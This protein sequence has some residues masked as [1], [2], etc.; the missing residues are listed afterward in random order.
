MAPRKWC[1][2][3]LLRGKAE[4]DSGMRDASGKPIRGVRVELYV[5]VDRLEPFLAPILFSDQ[6][7]ARMFGLLGLAGCFDRFHVRF[8]NFEVD[9]K[10]PAFSLQPREP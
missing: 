8:R 7:D 1:P 5:H 2:E 9:G 10:P 6:M 3:R 4:G